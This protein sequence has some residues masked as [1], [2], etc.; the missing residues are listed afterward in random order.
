M[1]LELTWSKKDTFSKKFP[2]NR[3]F[4]YVNGKASFF[5]SWSKINR[6][7][8]LNLTFMEDETCEPSS[9]MWAI[10]EYLAPRPHSETHLSKVT[11]KMMLGSRNISIFFTNINWNYLKWILVNW[12]Q[13]S[14]RDV[15]HT[16]ISEMQKWFWLH[17]N[18]M[19]NQWNCAVL[20]YPKTIEIHRSVHKYVSIWK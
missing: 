9:L 16:R 8:R 20:C 1:E 2:V 5:V 4:I 6:I 14:H 18:A 3:S 11:K 15:S 7:I 12:I 19:R 13:Q 10:V 17:E